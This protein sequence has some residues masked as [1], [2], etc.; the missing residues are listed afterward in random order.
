VAADKSLNTHKQAIDCRRIPA[1]EPL[2]LHYIWYIM[3]WL[4]VEGSLKLQVSFVKEPYKKDDILQ[5]SLCP[6]IVWYG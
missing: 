6:S 3:G 2:I 5:K 4:R 1:N